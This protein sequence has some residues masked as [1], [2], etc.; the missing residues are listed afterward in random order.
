M[1]ASAFIPAKGLSVTVVADILTNGREERPT[2]QRTIPRWMTLVVVLLV[3]AGFAADRWQHQREVD[4]V[5]HGAVAGRQSVYFAEARVGGMLQYLTPLLF[6]DGLTPSMQSSLDGLL[7]QAASDG[8]QSLRESR[9]ALAGSYVLPWHQAA[10]T[11][12]DAYVAYLD[13]V[14]AR[15]EA[16]SRDASTLFQTDPSIRENFMTALSA[17][18]TAVSHPDLE[19]GIELVKAG[20]RG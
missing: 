9:A 13:S 6:R 4:Q 17:L 1:N 11:A 5:L 19:R 15:Y 16:V 20:Y 10:R 18:R 3:A 8:A 12:R 2:R 7:Q 14:I